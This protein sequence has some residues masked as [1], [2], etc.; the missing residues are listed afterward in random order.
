MVSGTCVGI[1]GW[2]WMSLSMVVVHCPLVWMTGCSSVGWVY[3]V[4]SWQLVG[5][6]MV[7]SQI[8]WGICD[9]HLAAGTES[10]GCPPSSDV[11]IVIVFVDGL[12]PSSCSWSIPF[13][14]SS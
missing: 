4:S 11:S 2:E 14:W 9:S 8:Y 6:V 5:V 3:H 1:L 12:G 7:S 10:S 13:L